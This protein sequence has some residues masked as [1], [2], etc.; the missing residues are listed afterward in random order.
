MKMLCRSMHTSAFLSLKVHQNCRAGMDGALAAGP[1]AGGALRSASA[2]GTARRR[3]LG[4]QRQG[5]GCLALHVVPK[6]AA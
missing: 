2:S 6:L 5:T 3:T 4:R 1:V